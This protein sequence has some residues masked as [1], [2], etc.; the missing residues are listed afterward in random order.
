[1]FF[2]DRT[3]V[4]RSAERLVCPRK[5]V[6]LK[7]KKEGVGLRVGGVAP[8]PRQGGCSQF[9]ICGGPLKIQ[10]RLSAAICDPSVE[11]QTVA[12]GPQGLF[13][14]LRGCARKSPALAQMALHSQNIQ[15]IDLILSAS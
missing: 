5:K 11:T 8:P 4:Y 7:K 3:H 9:A 10:R 1:M 6:Y 15:I 2:G 13:V 12:P 14:Q